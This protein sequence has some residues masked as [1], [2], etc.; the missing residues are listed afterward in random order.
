MLLVVAVAALVVAASASAKEGEKA[1]LMTPIPLDS[2]PGSKLTV[3]WT[4]AFTENGKQHSFGAG[5]VFVRLLSATGAKTETADAPGYSNPF[6]ATVTV[7]EG[8]IGDV[9]IG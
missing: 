1:T 5:G 9:R 6:T 3:T 7:P 4:L 2:K 8:G